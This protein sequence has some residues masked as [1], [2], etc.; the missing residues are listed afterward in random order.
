MIPDDS[1]LA[2]ASSLAPYMA[3]SKTR[4]VPTYDLA[5]SN[6][7]HCDASD[8]PASLHGL[9]LTGPND[10]GHA[11]LIDAIARRY[12]MT[13]DRV[14]TAPGAGGANFLAF[15]ALVRPGDDVLVER[16]GYDPISG[17]LRLLGANVRRFE[18]RFE[19][20]YALDPDRIAA[21]LTPRTRL[22]VLTSPHNPSG[23]VASEETLEAVGIV[24]ERAGARVL[25]DEVYLDAVFVDRPRPAANLSDTF[26]STSSLTKAYGLSGL[27]SGWIL[28]APQVATAARRARDVVDG[29]APFITDELALAAFRDLDRLAARARAILE[30]NTAALAEF[31]RS[32]PELSWIRPRGGNVAFPRLEG[33]LDTRPLAERLLREYG[34]AVVPGVFFDEPAHLRIAFGCAAST[35]Q[36]GLTALG[37]VLDGRYL[38]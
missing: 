21:A 1:S 12:A 9:E 23:A 31:I 11:A 32:R 15:A 6:L 4:P 3:W 14:A 30:P 28:A 10:E 38:L 36:A 5:G 35:L 26:I 29:V 7:L 2:F 34:T 20:G 37:K 18:R 8:L 25:V 24:A 13:A 19:E 22:I 33:S 17:A 16:P 27:R